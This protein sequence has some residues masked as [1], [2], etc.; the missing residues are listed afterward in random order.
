M[1][2]RNLIA[3]LVAAGPWAGRFL[4][5]L[6]VLFLL[7]D[8]IIKML[9]LPVVLESFRQLGFPESVAAGIGAIELFCTLLYVIPRTSVLGAVLLTAIM[10]GAIA[11]HLRLGDPLFTHVLFGSYLGLF[12]W[13]GLFLRDGRLRGIFPLRR[14]A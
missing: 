12:I 11:S 8:G 9:R 10:G 2:W 1:Q 14:K 6:A 5:G 13:G 4:S 7:F 3:R